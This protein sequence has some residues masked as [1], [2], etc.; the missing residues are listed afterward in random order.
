MAFSGTLVTGGSGVGV[1]VSTGAATES[2]LIHRLIGEAAELETPLTRK[3]A[4]FSKIL[5]VAILGLA[6]VTYVF[7]LL[8]GEDPADLLVAAVALAVGAIPEGLPAAVTIT[9]AIGVSRMAGRNA[10]VRRLPVAEALGSTTVICT[11]KTGTLT[12]NRMTV[13]QV[14]AGG[15]RFAVPGTGHLPEGEL[16]LEGGAVVRA[17]DHPALSACLIAGVL[18]SDAQ[19]VER[20]GRWEVVG[21]PTEGALLAAARMGGLE[22]EALIDRHPRVDV[23]PF[24]SERQFMASAHSGANGSRAGTVYLKGSAERVLDMSAWVLDANGRE[25]E[26]DRAHLLAE[27]ARLGEQGL[28]VLAL[29]KGAVA[30]PRL[31]ED[32]PPDGLTFLGFQAMMDPPRPEAV[33]AVHACKQAGIAVKMITGDHPA[34]AVAI[35]E[36][37]G[38]DQH[39]GGTDGLRVLTGVEIARLDP[40]ELAQAVSGATVFARVAPEQKLRLVEALQGQGEVVAMTG[41]GINDAPALKQADIG[42]AMGQGGTEVARESADIVLADD[43][44]A[45]IEAAVEEGRRTFDNLTKFIVWTLPTNMGEGLLILAAVVAGVTLPVLARSRSCGSI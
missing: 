40:E 4:H 25:Q 28:R 26:L 17:S 12:E 27:A 7:G 19:M 1:V 20:D 41:D 8:R 13:T 30:D 15:Q 3:I 32:D 45:S 31:N 18:C 33:S 22:T 21:D 38:L 36:Q 24:E 37:I 34:T 5:T 6:L 35:A 2:G 14:V 43:N 11:D 10:I 39:R 16:S 9:L 23:I 44:F 29:A 42:V